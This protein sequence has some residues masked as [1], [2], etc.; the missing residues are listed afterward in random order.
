MQSQRQVLRRV[1]ADAA[2]FAEQVSRHS[3]WLEVPSTHADHAMPNPGN[4]REI[5]LLVEPIDEGARR[6]GMIGIANDMTA[7]LLASDIVVAQPGSG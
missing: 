6:G 2:Q 7:L 3:L 4:G 1:G 5:D